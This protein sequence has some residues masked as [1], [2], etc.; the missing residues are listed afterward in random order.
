MVDE[1]VDLIREQRQ[2]LEKEMKAYSSRSFIIP[3]CSA[4]FHLDQIHE[5]EM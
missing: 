5:I 4:W 1:E 3:S 2:R